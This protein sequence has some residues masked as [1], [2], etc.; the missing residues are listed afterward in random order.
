MITAK[1]T[2]ALFIIRVRRLAGVLSRFAPSSAA[3]E[4]APEAAPEAAAAVLLV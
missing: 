4:A 3:T 2:T 1:Q